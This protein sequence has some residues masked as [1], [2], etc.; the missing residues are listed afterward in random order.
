[1]GLQRRQRDYLG[2][3]EFSAL[4]AIDMQHLLEDPRFDTFE[5]QMRNIRELKATVAPLR[6][7]P[8]DMGRL[9]KADVPCAKV[10]TREEVLAQEQL[11][12]MNGVYD[13]HIAGKSPIWRHHCLVVSDSSRAL[14]RT[15]GQDTDR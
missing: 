14:V 5:N 11:A 6:M 4:T 9:R 3:Y 13:H 7:R 2:S 1:M 10:M 15:H 8:V 12:A